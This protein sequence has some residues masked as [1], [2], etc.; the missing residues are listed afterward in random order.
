MYGRGEIY[1]ACFLLAF[2]AMLGFLL[3]SNSDISL[4]RARAAYIPIACTGPDF[5]FRWKVGTGFAVSEHVVL[6]AGHVDCG[7]NWT[8]ISSDGGSTWFEVKPN[9]MTVSQNWDIR[10]YTVPDHTFTHRVQFR[11]AVLGD[12]VSGY[13]IAFNETATGGFV[14][15][16]DHDNIFSSATPIGGMSGSALISSDGY[17]LGMVVA[18]LPTTVGG[19][20]SNWVSVAIPS[21]ILKEF[22]R[23]LNSGTSNGTAPN[24]EH[25]PF[26]GINPPHGIILPK[27]P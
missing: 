26:R 8:E 10:A 25:P 23:E 1:F 27:L 7:S 5:G 14:M 21:S 3:T 18:G 17:I 11:D 16:I 24:E 20:S 12:K 2:T 19:Y 4:K 6:T 13:G 22:I 15:K 9:Q